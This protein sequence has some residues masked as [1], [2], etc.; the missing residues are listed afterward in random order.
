MSFSVQGK[1]DMFSEFCHAKIS[2]SKGVQL[3][4]E[5]GQELVLKKKDEK[6]SKE[7]KEKLPEFEVKFKALQQKLEAKV[8][9]MYLKLEE[10]TNK[11]SLLELGEIHED[12]LSQFTEYIEQLTEKN[13]EFTQLVSNV[14][15]YEFDVRELKKELKMLKEIDFKELKKFYHELEGEEIDE[16]FASY[17]NETAN[18]EENY[19]GPIIQE[20]HLRRVKKH[21][22][23]IGT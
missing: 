1:W 5:E 9:E 10:S 4:A 23:M 16:L 2:W 12:Y 22:Y 17:V 20:L 6:L 8:K 21:N 7:D 19:L 18:D 3:E 15:D 14:K 11:N 13:E